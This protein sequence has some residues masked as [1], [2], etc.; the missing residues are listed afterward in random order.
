MAN[1][2]NPYSIDTDY[3]ATSGDF[4]PT[5]GRNNATPASNQA[6]RVVLFRDPSGLLSL[7][8]VDA[9]D[10]LFVNPVN[11]KGGALQVFT[12]QASG[13][14][15]TQYGN[16]VMGRM[17]MPSPATYQA[18]SIDMTGALNVHPKSKATFNLIQTSVTCAAGKSLFSFY[19]GGSMVIRVQRIWVYSP[20]Q[21]TSGSLL[22]SSGTTYYPLI[23][24]MRRIS[25]HVK[26][27][28]TATPS[29][30]TSDTADTFDANCTAYSNATLTG[31]AAAAY[32]RQDVLT[33]TTSGQAFWGR[34]DAN[35]KVLVIR[36]GE[37]FSVTCISNG[38]I[39]SGSGT[40]TAT[41]DVEVQI[42]Q[43]SA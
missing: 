26:G 23:A 1:V 18:M 42:T 17:D 41:V 38:T 36:P 20:P 24:E 21:N 15:T 33:T 14:T 8:N 39:A 4:A 19:N 30:S 16:L 3:N 29:I 27:T 25:G 28:S 40:T 7:A 22:G 32:H 13:A 10:N 31:A 12:G 37:G 5:S 9:Q 2:D 34:S 11:P 6:G 43:A 35:A